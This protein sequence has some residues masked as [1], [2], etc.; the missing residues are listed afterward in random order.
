MKKQILKKLG[1]FIKLNIALICTSIFGNII[2]SLSP[3]KNLLILKVLRHNKLLSFCFSEWKKNWEASLRAAAKKN[4]LKSDLKM[5]GLI[6]LKALNKNSTVFAGSK[7][8]SLARISTLSLP[9]T[10]TFTYDNAFVIPFSYYAEHLTPHKSIVEKLMKN[11]NTDED[12][13]LLAELRENIIQQPLDPKFLD[14]LFDTIAT[15]EDNEILKQCS[16][17]IFRSSTNVEVTVISFIIFIY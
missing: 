2:F 6:P 5:K 7:A 17:V 12:V 9:N 1:K 13:K 16:G 11:E 10:N 4:S 14:D 3:K 15:W 8:T